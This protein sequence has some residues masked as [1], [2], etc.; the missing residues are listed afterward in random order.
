MLKC[1]MLKLLSSLFNSSLHLA[2]ALHGSVS[3]IKLVCFPV[4]NLINK[5]HSDHGA[6]I[7]DPDLDHQKGTHFATWATSTCSPST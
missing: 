3:Q 1:K 6:S 7:I 2:T 5:D 4:L